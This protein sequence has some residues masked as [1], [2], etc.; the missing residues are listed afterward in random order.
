M[1]INVIRADVPSVNNNVYPLSTLELAAELPPCSLYPKYGKI[2]DGG[3]V[4]P[5]PEVGKA[6]AYRIEDGWLQAHIHFLCPHFASQVKSGELVVRAAVI[7][8]TD[9]D[10]IAPD[11]YPADHM[12]RRLILTINKIDHLALCDP[13]DA[14][15]CIDGA[16][17]TSSA[18]SPSP[19]LTS[20]PT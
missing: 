4:Y 3:Y 1:W 19:A 6:D 8:V 11:G 9:P 5:D 12:V 13:R 18:P 10:D 2:E 20:T 17:N 14:S 15:W 7:A 16:C